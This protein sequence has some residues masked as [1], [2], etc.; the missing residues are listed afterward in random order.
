MTYP[1]EPCRSCGTDVIVAVGRGGRT[2]TVDVEPA[3]AGTVKLTYRGS[4]QPL[5]EMPGTARQFGATL[6]RPHVDTC[7]GRPR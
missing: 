5:A 3:R 2:I 7:T 1:T 4:L 6:R